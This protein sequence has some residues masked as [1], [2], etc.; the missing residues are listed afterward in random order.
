MATV[1][2]DRVCVVR[3]EKVAKHWHALVLYA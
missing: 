3:I 1:D 2:A